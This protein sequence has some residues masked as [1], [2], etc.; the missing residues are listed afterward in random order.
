[1]NVFRADLHCHSTAS[2]GSSSPEE[3]IDLAVSIGLQGLSITDHDTIAAYEKAIPAAQAKHLQ[4]ISGIE[5][6]A[7][8][9]G[10]SVHIL[11]YAFKLDS[12]AIHDFC[13]RHLERRIYRNQKVLHLLKT[14]GMPIE[15]SDFPETSLIAGH[16]V[17]RPHI[18]QAMIHKGYVSSV[19]EA[20]QLFLGDGKSCFVSGEAFSIEETIHTIHEAKGLAVIAHPHLIKN[21][22]TVSDLLQMPFDGIEGYY[23]R[24]F[25]HQEERWVKIGIKKN[26]VITGGSDFHGTVKPETPL[27][28][29]WVP[30]TTFSLLK[31]RHDENN[32]DLV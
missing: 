25:P 9:K 22:K 20:F 2:D 23:A 27:G 6:S 4:L 8:H 30:G 14:H 19:K 1:M 13:Q 7:M 24:F 16:P 17:G 32:I 28:C 3:L 21:Q 10:T 29:S 15:A 18:A 12:P 11:G 5:L 26:W 31:Q